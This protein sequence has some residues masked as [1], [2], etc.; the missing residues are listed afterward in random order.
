MDRLT[1]RVFVRGAVACGLIL[2]AH[3]AQCIPL[4]TYSLS[5]QQ[6]FG[7]LQMITN[8][9]VPNTVAS[10]SQSGA[11]N[12]GLYTGRALASTFTPPFVQVQG[13]VDAQATAELTSMGL[14]VGSAIVYYFAVEQTAP[15]PVDVV[16][17]VIQSNLHADASF[18]GNGGAFSDA[19]FFIQGLS[20]FHYE[21]A[22]CDQASCTS[23]SEMSFTDSASA[24]PG[25][26]IQVQIATG[27]NANGTGSDL[28]GHTG[29]AAFQAIVDPTIQIDPS[30][31]YADDFTLAFS[32]NLPPSAAA[33]EPSSIALLAI[34]LLALMAQRIAHRPGLHQSGF[35]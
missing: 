6:S 7:P 26:D 5:F 20:I 30:F 19:S 12:G 32:P 23:P 14:D 17:L 29:Q 18:A 24:K 16:P 25:Q 13:D 22:M 31:A 1:L 8:T 10:I 4:A 15:A 2:F 35:Q 34:G 21:A 27:G 28:D 9:V 3:Q 11:V 33:P